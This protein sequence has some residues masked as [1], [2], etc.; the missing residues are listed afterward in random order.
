MLINRTVARNRLLGDHPIG[1]RVYAFGGTTPI[2]VIGI[3]DDTRMLELDPEPV[4]QAF[5]DVRQFPPSPAALRLPLLPN[6]LYY[7]MRSATTTA[8][9]A[10]D[11]RALVRHV[12]PHTAIDN[13]A[14]MQQLVSNAIARRRLFAVLLGVFAVVA[15]TLAAVGIYG[16]MAYT[17]TRRTREIG[18][19][20]ALGASRRQVMSLV[21]G[22]TLTLTAVGIVLGLAGAA[23][24]TQYLGSLLFGVSPLDARTF[25]AVALVLGSIATL[26]ASVP[27]RRAMRVEPLIALHEE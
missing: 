24:V 12:D 14:T 18:I 22:Q 20:M 8:P 17:V 13:F 25:A 16:V 21:L 9:A 11:I 2:E 4:A 26:A 6:T 7:A 10:A 5:V 3:V 19:R 1:G 23:G 15:A 27:A